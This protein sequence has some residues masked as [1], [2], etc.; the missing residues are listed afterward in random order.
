MKA[1]YKIV[2]LFLSV[3]VLAAGGV[4]LYSR[5]TREPTISKE[6]MVNEYDYLASLQAFSDQELLALGYSVEDVAKL[7]GFSFEDALYE[8]AQLSDDVLRNYGYSEAQIALLRAYRE[9]EELSSDQ[10]KDVSAAFT[11]SMVLNEPRADDPPRTTQMTATFT[12]HWTSRPLWLETDAVTCGYA[13][14][15]ANNTSCA[16]ALVPDGPN[17]CTVRYRTIDGS[18]YTYFSMSKTTDPGGSGL[19]F[20][21]PMLYKDGASSYWAESGVFVVT[22]QESIPANNL[23]AVMFSFGYGHATQTGHLSGIKII[24]TFDPAFPVRISLVFSEGLD[25]MYNKTLLAYTSGETVVLD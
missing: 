25:S 10:L 2:L 14:V 15:S 21:V 24:S 17:Q 6:Y 22:V 9:G 12:W 13:G 11:G 7:R 23:G 1:R 5:F 18:D 16:L 8:R 4:F 20:D 3:C 19:S